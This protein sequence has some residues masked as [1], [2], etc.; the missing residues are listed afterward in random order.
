MSGIQRVRVNGRSLGRFINGQVTLIGTIAKFGS[1]RK[2]IE[3]DSTD[4]MKINVSLKDEIQADIG[5]VVEVCGIANSKAT[6]IAD[7][8]VVFDAEDAVDF[9]QEDYNDFLTILHVKVDQNRNL[10][11]AFGYN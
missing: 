5:A 9:D 3:L 4:Q 1:T 10:T 11:E 2:H 6:I 7:S 8:Y